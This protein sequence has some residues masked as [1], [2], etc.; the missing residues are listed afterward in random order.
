[1]SLFLDTGVLFAAVN[2]NDRGHAAAR[3]VFERIAAGEWRAV[4]T[5]DYVLAETLNLVQSKA[6]KRASAEA[7]LGLC[8][9]DAATPPVV[10]EVLRVHG[11]RFAGAV[12]RYRRHFASGLSLTDCT[13]LELME[14][15]RIAQ[16]A[17]FDKG[18]RG[19]VAVVGL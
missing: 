10:R 3:A 8:L 16:V 2:R 7:V 1:M 11:T 13:T 15:F 17:T 9:G 5:S 19:F 6:P 12:E 4:Y 14:T 18:F